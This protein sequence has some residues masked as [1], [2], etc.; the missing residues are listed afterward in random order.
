M[1]ESVTALEL[2]RERE[3]EPMGCEHEIHTD[4]CPGDAPATQPDG[5]TL[6]CPGLWR[7]WTKLAQMDTLGTSANSVTP[8]KHSCIPCSHSLANLLQQKVEKA[9]EGDSIWDFVATHNCW[10]QANS[11]WVTGHSANI[12]W[13]LCTWYP[14]ARAVTVEQTA[15][16]THFHSHKAHSLMRR[17]KKKTV[18]RTLG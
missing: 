6:W 2:G 10:W 4:M 13:M 17:K 11:W 5:N 8:P 14:P 1:I 9:M 15:N 18:I 16:N 3:T 7:L 12:Y